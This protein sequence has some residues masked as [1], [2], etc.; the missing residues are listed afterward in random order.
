M[1]AV[2]ILILRSLEHG[3]AIE[4]VDDTEYAKA[5]SDALK[6]ASRQLGTLLNTI[7]RNH[8]D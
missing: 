4:P 1:I 3:L 7:E 2:D 8:N 5:Y 6:F